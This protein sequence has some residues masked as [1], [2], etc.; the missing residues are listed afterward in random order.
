MFLL[1]SKILC[2]C[3]IDSTGC[4]LMEDP[5]RKSGLA[6]MIHAVEAAHGPNEVVEITH[7]LQGPLNMPQH[8]CASSLLIFT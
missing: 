7:G 2:G 6:A 4:L 8:R 5:L 1:H 3:V